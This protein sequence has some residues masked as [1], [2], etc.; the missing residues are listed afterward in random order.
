MY[1]FDRHQS[2]SFSPSVV[3]PISDVQSAAAI[4]QHHGRGITSSMTLRLH[5]RA[6]STR[7]SR[8][9]PKR[10]P[11][12]VILGAIGLATYLAMQLARKYTL[13]VRTSPTS[14][15]S[16]F[17]GLGTGTEVRGLSDYSG[18]SHG[19][20]MKSLTAQTLSRRQGKDSDFDRDA[21]DVTGGAG[22]TRG[23]HAGPALSRM[24]TWDPAWKI[25]VPVSPDEWRATSGNGG[26][27]GPGV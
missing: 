12:L 9:H 16:S 19:H 20:E 7:T 4:R 27:L 13:V 22:G 15:P 21:V 1:L 17:V 26:T 24:D 23:G 25:A 10:R 11:Y 6:H 18:V 8:R 3:Y 5:A 2:P 14:D